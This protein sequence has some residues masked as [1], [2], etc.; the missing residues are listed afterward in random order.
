MKTGRR[1]ARTLA[2]LDCEVILK[3]SLFSLVEQS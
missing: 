2:R 3:I 1:R